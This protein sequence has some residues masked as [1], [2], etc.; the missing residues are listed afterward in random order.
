MLTGAIELLSSLVRRR[1]VFAPYGA[2]AYNNAA[3]Y[4]L[5]MV[6]ESVSNKTYD[7][8]LEDQIF[9]PLGLT[10]TSVRKPEDNSVGIIPVGPDFWS[11]DLG[12]E[13]P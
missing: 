7:A 13:N 8:V 3:F 4:I 2:V 6:I 1:P 11:Y 5:G 9:G 12:A 10:R